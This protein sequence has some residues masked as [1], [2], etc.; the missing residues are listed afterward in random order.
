MKSFKNIWLYVSLIC[1]LCLYSCDVHEF[2]YPVEIEYTLHLD[3]N[4]ELPLHKVVEYYEDVPKSST[5]SSDFDI[6]YI[7]EATPVSSEL[8]P[9]RFIFTQDDTENLNNKFTLNLIE[10]EYIFKIW[11]D[12]IP[13]GNEDDL[14][15]NTEHFENICLTEG[16]YTGS[17]D[18]KDAFKGSVTSTLSVENTSDTVSMKRPV[19]K[20]NFISTDVD[21]FITKVAALAGT[22]NG[23]SNIDLSDYTIVFAYQGF[24]PSSFN[25]DTDKP[26][27]SKT[28]LAFKSKIS[29]FTD[30]E[31]ELGFDYIFVHDYETIVTVAIGVYDNEGKLISQFRPVDV[32]LMRS[33]L[34]TVKGNFLTA[35]TGGSVGILPDFEGDFNIEIK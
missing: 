18:W 8:E 28:N 9:E 29:V 21:K 23:E 27:D 19:A 35:E 7:I 24:V 1:G 20:F 11:T 3:Y 10:G 15:Y 2:P 34:T 13:S 30:T 17:S 25:M 16:E 4:I 14:F 26:G 31:A 33:K 5:K 12:Y 6:R 32:P 22:K